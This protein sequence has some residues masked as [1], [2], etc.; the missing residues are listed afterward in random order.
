MKVFFPF[1]KRE[2][3][4]V[5]AGFIAIKMVCIHETHQ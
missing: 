4:L 5:L 2:N 1:S 3:V